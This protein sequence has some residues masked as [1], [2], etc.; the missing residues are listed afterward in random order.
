[1][2]I[3]YVKTGNDL[4]Y[5][6][7][8][9]SYIDNENFELQKE[10]NQNTEAIILGP[11]F[12]SDGGF[13]SHKSLI[14]SNNYNNITKILYLNKEYKN[15]NEKLNFIK[16]NK[17]DIVFTVH[18]DYKKWNKL[19]GEKTKF[20]KLPFAYNHNVFKDYSLDKNFDIG[21]TGNF[22]NAPVYKESSIMGPNFNNC[23]ERI[24]KLLEDEKQLKDK[25][26]KNI[27]GEGV[28]LK[29]EQ[30][31]KTINNT[32]IWISTPSAIDIVGTRFY[33]VMGC[34]TLLFAKY[35]PGIYD[36]IFEPDKHFVTFKD[37]LSDLIEKI[38]FY[39]ENDKER[40]EISNSG[41]TLVN[42]EHRWSNRS[43]AVY[44]IL[45]ANNNNKALINN[46]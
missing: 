25:N 1:M 8:Y 16:N 13:E 10:I 38:I 26:L 43:E 40:K 41:Y 9:T 33:E 18:H 28:Y 30:Y 5:D 32:K 36:G 19:C 34:N 29:G 12:L 46:L 24:F 6:S 20:F 7:I 27:I 15:L 39:L 22:F 31:G 3:C 4:Y 44:D 17:I 37:D 23:R 14:L 11:G 21:F 35:I 2:K 45:K 42:K